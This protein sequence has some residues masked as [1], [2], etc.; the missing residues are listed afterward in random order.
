MFLG[1][2]SWENQFSLS[3]SL[4]L[5]YI[6]EVAAEFTH[7]SLL[8][9][10]F[11]LYIY[12]TH[13]HTHTHTYPHLGVRPHIPS[14][15]LVTAKAMEN[16]LVPLSNTFQ[17]RVTSNCIPVTPP[18]SKEPQWRAL[19]KGTA[20]QNSENHWHGV[21]TPNWLS[22]S[23]TLLLRFEAF[24]VQDFHIVKSYPKY[25]RCYFVDLMVCDLVKISY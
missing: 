20:D 11:I 17:T 5:I 3:L 19:Q 8:M 24:N 14:Q 25:L 9:W 4:S 15:L 1:L 6:Y 10:A 12:S 21:P 16:P 18:S 13:T 7:W 22:Y 23:T 2:T